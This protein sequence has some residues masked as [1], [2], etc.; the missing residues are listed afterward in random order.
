MQ[1]PV[2]LSTL[3]QWAHQLASHCG[4]CGQWIAKQGSAKEHI[5]RMHPA[6]WDTGLDAFVTRCEDY[7]DLV[8][9]EHDYELCEQKVHSV[10]RHIRNCV[11]LFQVALATAWHQAGRPE[12]DHSGHHPPKFQ[13][14]CRSISPEGADGTGP[15]SGKTAPLR[16]TLWHVQLLPH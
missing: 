7:R 8:T 16:K 9:R 14:L 12:Q 15:R 11:V 5:K 2:P 4:F 13:T 1:P 6:V 10:D 3:V